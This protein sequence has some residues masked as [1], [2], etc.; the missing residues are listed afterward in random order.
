[1]DTE[2]PG[3]E[4]HP[5]NA[6]TV[7]NLV[8]Q[9][10]GPEA[11][12]LK[13]KPHLEYLNG[14]L[15]KIGAKMIVFEPCY[16][17]RDF[18]E[19][20]SEYYVRCFDKYASRCARL[21]FFETSFDE[22]GLRTA[23]VGKAGPL[24]RGKL[25]EAYLGF[26]VI[27][28]LPKTF[29]GR[30]C[31]RV[32]PE[33][34]GRR[35]PVIREY[36]AHL[37]GLDLKVES[38]AFQEQDTITAACAT[39]AL[40]SA[41]QGTGMLFHHEIPSPVSITKA[42]TQTVPH[43]RRSL[44]SKGLSAIQMASAIKAVGL[45]PEV[46]GAGG[47]QLVKATAYA[48]LRARLPILLIA[49]ILDFSDPD[50]PVPYGNGGQHALHAVAVTGFRQGDGPVSPYPEIGTLF[51]S[52]RL[53]RLYVHD[54]QVGPFARIVFTDKTY[55][56]EH[57][58]PLPL[59]DTTWPSPSQNAAVCFA[60]STLIV[61]LYHKIRIPFDTVLR[62]VFLQDV[63]FETKRQYEPSIL[64]QRLTWDVYLTTSS[65][66]KSMICKDRLLSDDDRW[67]ALSE[68]FPR[69]LWRAVAFD[70]NTP[71]I[72]F[73]FDATDIEQGDYL[74]KTIRHQPDIADL[75]LG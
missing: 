14:Y 53:T 10:N 41:F 7:V 55:Q 45:E 6:E 23:V 12:A 16:T 13:E 35:Y 32:Y 74:F 5:Y 20:Y 17:D 58:R 47:S 60:P 21:H 31:L 8:S 66:W 71:V 70:G 49:E 43:L 65:E 34:D 73:L 28:P 54:D 38:L 30:T 4:V 44:P 48:Y 11:S 37:L 57:G 67:A 24:T 64:S 75:L 46:A 61:P 52:D 9:C 69:F 27:K 22:D 68:P 40:W 51:A 15:N 33:K 72:E 59:M 50:H 26:M 18:L 39:S 3:V 25:Q 63:S 42:A 1:M 36:E 19:D 62:Q 29:I 2:C 56:R